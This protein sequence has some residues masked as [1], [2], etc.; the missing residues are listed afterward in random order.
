MIPIVDLHP[1][2]TAS[3]IKFCKVFFS[4]SLNFPRSFSLSTYLYIDLTSQSSGCYCLPSLL[5]LYTTQFTYNRV[6]ACI[7]GIV[8]NSG[9]RLWISDM[10]TEL[11]T[12]YPMH[13][14]TEPTNKELLREKRRN[15]EQKLII[16]HIS[17][18]IQ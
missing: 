11:A 3:I 18:K 6:R 17:N 1:I 10:V 5:M 2:D 16:F 15:L 14:C 8:W 4:V 12:R 13:L 7:K 9:L